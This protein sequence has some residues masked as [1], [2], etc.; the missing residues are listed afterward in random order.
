[1][2][3]LGAADQ[4]KMDQY[5]TSVRTVEQQLTSAVDPTG[6][7]RNEPDPGSISDYAKRFAA[8]MELIVFAFKCDLTRVITF[9]VG[10]AFGPGPMPWA[11]V[12][13]DYHALTHN[14]GA[15]GVKDQIL[16]CIQWEVLQVANLMKSLKAIP[17]G[18]KTVLYNSSILVTSDVGDGGLHNHD[19]LPVLL[20]GNGGGAFSGG[21]YIAYTPEDPS[22]RTLAATR[23]AT[24][25][26]QALA[27]PNTNK[28]AN[29][30][31][32]LLQT[33][34]VNTTVGDSTG[35]LPR[36]T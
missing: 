2:P 9:M 16:K 8:M 31:V 12:N 32:S 26:T 22:A 27:I 19:K 4:M 34:G 30:H 6:A 17:E 11:G 7:C 36:L 24:K 13:S 20:G 5:L 1:M 25:R 3:Q 15:A 10:N 33:I 35:P 18:D 23:D 14:Q 28:L 21:Q 29:L